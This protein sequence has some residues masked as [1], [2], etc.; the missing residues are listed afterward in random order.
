VP[1]SEYGQ[2]KRRLLLACGLVEHPA[3]AL[4]VL[5]SEVSAHARRLWPSIELLINVR[6]LGGTPAT[7]PLPLTRRFL[8]RWVPMSE[9]SVRAAMEELEAKGFVVRAGMHVPEHGRPMNL[10]LPRALDATGW[11]LTPEV[12]AG[13]RS[14]G[15]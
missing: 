9:R 2:W 3:V 10:W 8:R 15:D 5:P 1:P 12:T 4:A 7:D 6:V 11:S 13:G 14:S